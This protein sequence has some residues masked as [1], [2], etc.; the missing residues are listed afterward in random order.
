[1]G[2]E[3]VAYT[4]VTPE[5]GNELTRIEMRIDRLLKR[6]EVPGFVAVSREAAAGRPAPTTPDGQPPEAEEPAAPKP[7]PL[8]GRGGRPLRRIRRAL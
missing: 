6:D 8:Y 5:E 7:A 2:R 3:G 1:M 4:F